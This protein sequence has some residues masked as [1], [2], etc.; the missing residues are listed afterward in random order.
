[1]ESKKINTTLYGGPSIFSKQKNRFEVDRLFC[2]NSDNCSFYKNGKCLMAERLGCIKCK[3]GKIVREDGPGPRAK[4]YNL[5]ANEIRKEDTYNKLDKTSEL[6][7]DFGDYYFI[8]IKYGTLYHDLKTDKWIIKSPFTYPVWDFA[9]KDVQKNWETYSEFAFMPKESL[10]PQL[11]KEILTFKPKAFFGNEI[12][13][14][15]KEVVPLIK[16]GVLRFAPELAKE[17]NIEEINY[18]GLQGELT[19]LRGPFDFKYRDKT[20]H[21]DGQFVT[22]TDF[23]ILD[24]WALPG[25]VIATFVRVKPKQNIFITIE[26]NSWVTENSVIKK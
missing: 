20:F 13:S 25:E 24:K 2:S 14:Y 7:A 15:Q 6:F 22:S 17:C 1:M 19:T 12:V 4:K 26:D 5:F 8:N 3:Y 16:R 18:V 9:D 21:Y 11:L 10:T 23:G